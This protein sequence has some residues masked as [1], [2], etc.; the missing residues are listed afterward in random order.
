MPGGPSVNCRSQNPVYASYRHGRPWFAVE[1]KL[2]AG[3]AD[4]SIGYF[5]HRLKIPAAYQV[6]RDGSR[7]RMDRGVRCLPAAPF[8][9]AL[10]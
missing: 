6:T 4:P 8:L 5:T 2:T 1:A 7:D 9:A 10:A 3:A